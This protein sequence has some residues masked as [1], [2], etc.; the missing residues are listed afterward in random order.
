MQPARFTGA[1][2]PEIQSMKYAAGQTFKKGAVVIYEGGATGNIIEGGVDPATV[3][4]VALEAADSKPGFS[5]SH[6]SSVVT[7]TGNVSEVSVAKANRQ[8]VFSS[9][10]V[11][12]GTDPVTPVQADIGK[13]YG[14]LKVGNDWC[15]DQSDV[16]NT[17]LRVTDIDIDNKIVFFKWLEAA[18]ATP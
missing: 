11:N 9:R 15:V 8:T 3:V 2:A 18:L 4:G 10:M 13:A 7:R 14:V 16:V 12:G 17:R 1:T 6:D 5:L